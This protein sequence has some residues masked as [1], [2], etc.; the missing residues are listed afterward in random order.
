MAPA[1]DPLARAPET[2]TLAAQTFNPNFF[3]DLI[4]GTQTQRRT[5]I[6]MATN[7]AQPLRV[8]VLPRYVGLKPGDNDGPRPS[9]R[10]FFSYNHYA[11]VNSSVNP[12]GSPDIWL[13]REIVGLE[14]TLGSDA[15]VG[16]RLPFLQTGGS[17][18][19]EAREIGDLSLVG[20][21]ALVNDDAGNVITVGMILTLPTGGR[22]ESL[23]VLD[24]GTMAPRTLFLQ[25]WAGAVLTNGDL[26]VQAVTSVVLPADPVYPTALF[27]SV[28][29]GY[30][31]YRNRADTLIQ[32]VVPM[33][34]LHVNTPLTNRG[35]GAPIFFRDQVNLTT[36]LYLQF[37][38]LTVGGAVCVPLVNPKPYDLEMMVNVNYQF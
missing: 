28:G 6:A 36:G 2:G 29:V 37:P 35:D 33:A 22:G 30:W 5:P 25:P 32:G 21:Y 27:N 31:V 11:G 17:S 26:L 15:S 13:N 16:V 34:E 10:V 1:V 14:T 24:D 9:D 18:T 20:K 19:F 7:P 23:G 4:G 38:R 3:G 12:P 8:P